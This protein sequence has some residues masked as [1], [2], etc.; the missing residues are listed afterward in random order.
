MRLPAGGG[1]AAARQCARSAQVA[2]DQTVIRAP[3]DGVILTKNANVGDNITPF[4]SQA[5]DSKGAVVTI[6]DM[7]TL[8]VE[9]DVSESNLEQNHGRPAGR[10]PAR[11]LPQSAHGGLVSRMVPTVDR[12]KATLLVKVRFV[13][14]D[15]RVLPDMSARWRFLSKAVRAGRKQ[16]VTAVQPAAIVSATASR[17]C[18]WS[19]TDKVTRR[20]GHR[21]GPQDRRPG[22]VRG[23]KPGQKVVMAPDA[24]RLRTARRQPGEEMSSTASRSNTWQSRIAAATR[25]RCSGADRHHAVDPRRRLHGADGAFRIGQEH[26]AQSDRGHR[27]ARQR[28]AARRRASTSRG[29]PEAALADWRAA[30]VGFIF[31]F[32]NLMPVLSAFENVELPLLLTPLSRR[33]RRERVELVLEMVNLADRMDHTIPNELSGGQQQRVAIARAIVTDPT[34][35]VADE[36]T[37]DLDRV[38][39][40][41]VLA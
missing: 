28:R 13:D 18:S 4:S 17:W 37:G 14:L 24:E 23:V 27:Q 33:E 31:Q 11:R 36:P 38:S 6:A 25:S 30:N 26:A 1:A 22:E 41:D 7:E 32:Y 16:P 29:C 12:S 39:A 34:L 10:N 19:R 15:P 8:E 2:L 20:R 5:A 21:A 35:I 40:A 9:A 3:F